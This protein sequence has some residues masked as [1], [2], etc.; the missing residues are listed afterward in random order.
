MGASFDVRVADLAVWI[1]GV[2]KHRF[3]PTGKKFCFTQPLR[4]L[5]MGAG[6]SVFRLAWLVFELMADLSSAP[7]TIPHIRYRCVRAVLWF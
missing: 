2:E 3:W 5:P 7:L 4:L 6:H 1:K